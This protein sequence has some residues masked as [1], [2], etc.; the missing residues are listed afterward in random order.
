MKEK[1]K[2][3]AKKR[4]GKGQPQPEEGQAKQKDKEATG[5]VRRIKTRPGGQPARPSQE[6]RAHAHTH[7]TPVRRRPTRNRRCRRPH[8]TPPV[9]RPSPP[10]KDGRYERPDATVPGST[11]PDH[12]SARSPRRTPEGPAM[13]NAI[14]GP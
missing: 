1:R 8:K 10:S 14:A 2:R 3:K 7:R 9:H 6:E 12:R 13:D 4:T 11:N 5:K